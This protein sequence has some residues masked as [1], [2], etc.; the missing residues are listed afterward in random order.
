MRP[1]DQFLQ[2][3]LQNILDQMSWRRELEFRLLQF[4]LIFFPVIGTAMVALF[5]SQS[6][7]AQAYLVTAI[8]VTLLITVSSVFVSD[9]IVH[10]HTAYTIL[11]QQAQKILLPAD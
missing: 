8:G 11:G 7:S 2:D 9:R 4:L 1:D 3:Y 6:V 10:E 5:E